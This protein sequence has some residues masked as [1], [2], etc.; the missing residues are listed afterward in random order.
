[1]PQTRTPA[2][3]FVVNVRDRTGSFTSITDIRCAMETVLNFIRAVRL[4]DLTPQIWDRT[5]HLEKEA[6]L[7]FATEELERF[8]GI[9]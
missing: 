6:A 4:K 3:R 1:V 2:D 9:A 5:E 8:K 7:E